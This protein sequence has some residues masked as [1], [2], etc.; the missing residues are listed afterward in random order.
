MAEILAQWQQT[1]GAQ[2]SAFDASG[3]TTQ[4]NALARRIKS[5]PAYLENLHH[6]PTPPKLDTGFSGTLMS[7]YTA[8]YNS[9]DI[10][11]T[12]YRASDKIQANAVLNGAS[13]E[14]TRKRI[15]PHALDQKRHFDSIKD[16]PWAKVLSGI[17][18]AGTALINPAAG[19]AW[20]IASQGTDNLPKSLATYG[21][22]KFG[23]QFLPSIDTVKN[24]LG[25]GSGSPGLSAGDAWT[26]KPHAGFDAWTPGGFAP[27]GSSALTGAS[28][29]WT[30]AQPTNFDAWS[31]GSLAPEGITDESLWNAGGPWT[32][33]DP[34]T[35]QPPADFDAY[36][37]GDFGPASQYVTGSLN[38]GVSANSLASGALDTLKSVGG[39]SGTPSAGAL[40]ED[41]GVSSVQGG[42]IS[43][44]TGGFG[45]GGNAATDRLNYALTD[46]ITGNAGSTT[47]ALARS[48]MGSGKIM[49]TQRDTYQNPGYQ[50]RPFANFLM[51]G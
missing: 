36:T 8:A 21:A 3:A 1:P 27:D 16:S 31:P 19:A 28:S 25:I 9:V 40:L 39:I 24:K 23:A 49:P 13:K 26:T 4:N 50:P 51:R 45:I 30:R 33:G 38:G 20:G 37:P 5:D 17:V 35:R 41:G 48:G 34:W 46:A 18:G 7:P 12:G 10:D 11:P 32:P 15:Q 43:P 44:L 42:S 14:D 22:G 2:Q 29:A 6:T 47:N